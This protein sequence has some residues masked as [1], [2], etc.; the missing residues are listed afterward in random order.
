MDDKA[1]NSLKI[2]QDLS[3]E[4]LPLRLLLAQ[5]HF[6]RGEIR[7]A[8]ELIKSIAVS[9]IENDEAHLLLVTHINA[10]AMNWGEVIKFAPTQNAVGRLEKAKALFH[11]GHSQEARDMYREIV[12]SNPMLEDNSFANV[13]FPSS[14]NETPGKKSPKLRLVS[15]GEKDNI[16][17]ADL[18]EPDVATTTFADIGGLVD[19][20]KTIYRKIIQPYQKPSLF[21]IYKKKAGGGVLLYGPPGCGKTLLARATAGECGAKFFNIALSDVLDMYIG[22]SERKLKALFDV[23]RNNSPSVLFFDEIEG[24]GSRRQHNQANSLANVVS[25]FLSEM[26][27]FAQDNTGV[28]ILGA[29][30]LPWAVDP[31]F[32]R[33][34]RFDRVLFVAPPDSEARQEILRLQMKGRPGAENIDLDK[35]ARKT[36]GFSGADL[37][38]LIETAADEAIESSLDT[39]EIRPIDTNLITE[40]MK[41]VRPTTMEWLGSAKNYARYANEGGLY[42]EVL[43]FLDRHGKGRK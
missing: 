25:Q 14:Q 40:M 16:D 29:T 4:N 6:D 3:P 18:V 15:G 31:A 22:E 9:H 35:I 30:N 38:N 2:A 23:A 1:I 34:G 17:V 10:A 39:D 24:L 11:L 36:S 26:D 19:V 13:L 8:L 33:P 32:R 41:E 43:T 12:Q 5:A 42:D 27:G 28:L 37:E 20:K 21:R 7:D